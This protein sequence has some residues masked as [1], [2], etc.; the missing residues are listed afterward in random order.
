M[1]NYVQ[2]KRESGQYRGFEGSG[3]ILI[4]LTHKTKKSTLDHWFI[5]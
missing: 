3:K 2:I 1:E 5:N 4:F